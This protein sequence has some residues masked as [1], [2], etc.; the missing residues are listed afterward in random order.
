MQTDTVLSC[1]AF[2]GFLAFPEE[3]TSPVDT[4]RLEGFIVPHV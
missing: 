3:I 2:T 4:L 1:H